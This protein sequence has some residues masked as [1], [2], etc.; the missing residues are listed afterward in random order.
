MEQITGIVAEAEKSGKMTESMCLFWLEFMADP[1]NDDTVLQYTSEILKRYPDNV[2]LW[3][4]YLVAKTEVVGRS[5]AVPFRNL[6]P[7][8]GFIS[9]SPSSVTVIDVHS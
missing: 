4:K 1:Q 7:L 6:V 8:S 9:Y 3:Q 5:H 2:E